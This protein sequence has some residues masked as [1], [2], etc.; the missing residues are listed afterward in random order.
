MDNIFYKQLR[1]DAEKFVIQA[2]QLL[3]QYQKKVKTVKQKDIAD[4]AT[5]ADLASEQ[6]IIKLIRQKYP[7]H[8]IYSEEAGESVDKSEFRWIIDPLDG[9]KEYTKGLVEYNCL[10]AV[11]HNKRLVAGAAFRNG[12]NE[13]YTSTLGYGAF[14]NGQQ[15]HVSKTSDVNKSFIG[16][17]IP[18][19]DN[20]VAMINQSFRLLQTLNKAC[21][22]VRPGW[23]DTYLM[24]MVARG[25]ID[26]HLVLNNKIK[27]CDVAPAVLL[28]LEAGG[29]VTD[30][31]GN[32][33]Q[34]GD[35]SHGLLVSNSVL[36]AYL[37]SQIKQVFGKGSISLR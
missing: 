14:L 2:V 20:S 12:T 22:R 19:S 10:V 4:I 21:Y 37:L 17:H 26:A 35:L 27:W 36:P 15:I 6:L 5:N 25:I 9:T 11:E 31:N 16:F 18:A 30:W 8:A 3:N 23:D 1:H 32:P 34:S 29:S 13:L 24:S 33:I 7:D 28:V